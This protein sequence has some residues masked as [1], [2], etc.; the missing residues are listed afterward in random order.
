MTCGDE[1]DFANDWKLRQCYEIHHAQ[2]LEFST[3]G[4]FLEKLTEEE[5]LRRARQ[6]FNDYLCEIGYLKSQQRK[7]RRSKL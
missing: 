3:E 6:M 2:S 4:R 5:Y 7:R 1:Q